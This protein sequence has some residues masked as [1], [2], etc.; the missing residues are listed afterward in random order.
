MEKSMKNLDDFL[1][2]AYSYCLIPR[3]HPDMKNQLVALN[4]V[5]IV[6]MGGLG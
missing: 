6:V 1:V 3:R 4:F 5:V 2:S